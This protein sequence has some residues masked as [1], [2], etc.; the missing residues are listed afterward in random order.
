[1][2]P[3]SQ[4]GREVSLHVGLRNPPQSLLVDVILNH[5][6]FRPYFSASTR[7]PTKPYRA[8]YSSFKSSTWVANLS[9][10]FHRI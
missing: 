6:S 7:P 1:M 5:L 10:G 4:F 8:V 3:T 9:S 2:E